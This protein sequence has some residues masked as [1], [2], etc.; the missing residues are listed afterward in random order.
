VNTGIVARV[1]AQRMLAPRKLFHQLADDHVPFDDL[2]GTE[3]YET[4]ALRA[5]VGDPVCVAVQGPPGSGKSSLIAHVCRGLP[6]T[7]VALRVPVTGADDPTNVSVV[8]AAALSQALN[9][10][11][12]ERHQQNA[13]ERARADTVERGAD[14]SPT[15]G[16]RLGGGAIPVEVHGEVGTLRE[17][18]AQNQLARDR[19]AGL[20]R[21]IT[22]LVARGLQP[23]F[24]LEDTEAA[25]G[26]GDRADVVEAFFDGPVRAFMNELAAASLIAVQDRFAESRAFNELAPHMQIVPL[27]VFDSAEASGAIAAVIDQRLGQFELQLRSSDVLSADATELLGDFYVETGGSWRHALV[28]AQSAA[29]IA[30][31]Q[32][33]RLVSVG[34]VRAAMAD[35]RTRLDRI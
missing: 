5:A 33:A 1:V 2:S 17:Q 25:V 23:V 7:H 20:D 3:K 30:H 35:W 32:S 15:V 26:G 9:D 27:P 10:I 11:E 21:L 12:L 18:L 8:A 14:V 4:V 29:E 13:L 6:E 22:I 28:A 31:D 19:L 16:G 24:V 34:H